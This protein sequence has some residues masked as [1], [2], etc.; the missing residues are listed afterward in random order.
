MNAM[1]LYAIL[2]AVG[3]ATGS[4]SGFW[5]AHTLD[6]TEISEAKRAAA[7]S[8]NE[9]EHADDVARAVMAEQTVKIKDQEA[10]AREFQNQLEKARESQVKTATDLT[11]KLRSKR[12]FS[13]AADLKNGGCTVSGTASPRVLAYA[14][15]AAEFSER[16]DQLV[17]A[18]AAEADAVD[19]D[20][21]LAQQW[22][23][24]L[25]KMPDANP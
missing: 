13:T 3:F 24:S 16:L 1:T 18:K 4:G 21:G 6:A 12:L 17:R 15:A 10:K 8:K 19:R 22:A 5:L 7:T 9:R 25:V 23:A 20:F 11:D 14:E 2:I